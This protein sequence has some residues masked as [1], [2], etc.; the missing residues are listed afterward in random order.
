M[1]LRSPPSHTKQEVVGPAVTGHPDIFKVTYTIRHAPLPVSHAPW[2]CA[3]RRI[4]IRE[5]PSVD[6]FFFPCA[7]RNFSHTK[8]MPDIKSEAFEIGGVTWNVLLFPQ[9][10]R[11]TP[12]TTRLYS[13]PHIGLRRGSVNN[14]HVDHPYAYGRQ[15]RRDIGSFLRIS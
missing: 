7:S 11:S 5:G 4:R 12:P 6:C 8:H 10:S 2:R 9:G 14:P 1:R 15:S 13:F 3:A